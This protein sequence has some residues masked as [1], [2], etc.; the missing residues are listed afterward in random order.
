MKTFYISK[1]KKAHV[2][3]YTNEGGEHYSDL[4]S[5]ETRV[6][7]YNHNTNKI[8]IYGWYSNTT[9]KHVNDFLEFYGFDKLTKKEMI[10]ES[11]IKI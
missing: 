1:N 3:E 7:S 9:T 8:S 11:T 2:N 4:I 5:Y 10:N 6:A